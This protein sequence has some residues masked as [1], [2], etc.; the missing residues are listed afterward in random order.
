MLQ[1]L[2]KRM[3]F[4]LLVGARAI[5]AMHTVMPSAT[6]Q[7]A[8]RTA[9]RNCD[10]MASD[11]EPSGVDDSA[12]ALRALQLFQQVATP[13]AMEIVD[14]FLAS[15]TSPT[16]EQDSSV[17]NLEDFLL[18]NLQRTPSED[19]DAFVKEWRMFATGVLSKDR[20]KYAR[21]GSHPRL[22]IPD[23]TDLV[24]EP[25]CVDRVSARAWSQWQAFGGDDDR[26]TALMPVGADEDPASRVSRLGV[27]RIDGCLSPASAS[28]L[29]AFVLAER[30]SIVSKA[31]GSEEAGTTGAHACIVSQTVDGSAE[32]GTAEEHPEQLSR[33]LSATNAGSQ[34]VTRWDVR[35][36]WDDVVRDA[37]HEILG[38][39]P[40]SLGHA[41]STLSGGDS[42]A[43]FECAAIISCEGAAPQ[44]V[45]SDTVY[46]AIEGPHLHTAFV[47]L[48]DV[49]PHQGP[50][51][52]LPE[53]HTCKRSHKELGDNDE[54]ACTD[55][56]ET[57]TS[58]SA[59]LGIGDCSLYDSRTLH[60]GGPHRAAPP[61]TDGTAERVL[62]YVSF[63]HAAISN[64]ALPNDNVH[65]PGSILPDVAKMQLDLGALRN[66]ALHS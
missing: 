56:C 41:F 39:G 48:Q 59:L 4:L 54:D 53:T 6:R 10:L 14:N 42:A 47:A 32:G 1:M 13:E 31:A 16:I 55:F 11:S 62:F 63:R 27:V 21:V 33:V 46:D 15:L 37:V 34:T 43:L 20:S 26:A 60:C 64:I 22:A 30:D 38:K 44:R 5:A 28:T 8:V 9:L 50:T 57:A 17:T 3:M 19:E 58:V 24:F 12:P 51:R 18:A 2:L 52:F 65:G 61:G 36:P 7:A 25:L 35:L 29:R 45:H 23:T 40:T 49:K 66:P